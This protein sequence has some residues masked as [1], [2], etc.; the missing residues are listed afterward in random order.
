[1]DRV[2]WD[3]NLDV[4]V[5]IYPIMTAELLD[6]DILVTLKIWYSTAVSQYL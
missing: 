5:F 2:C 4:F 3:S 1:M 6:L